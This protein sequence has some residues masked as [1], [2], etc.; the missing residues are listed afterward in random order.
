MDCS[1]HRAT[2]DIFGDLE[3]AA[4]R[5]M[6]NW[7]PESFSECGPQN[8]PTMDSDR[9]PERYCIPTP[10][11]GA[12]MGI[13]PWELS[14]PLGNITATY[15]N[16][17]SPMTSFTVCSIC[18]GVL[19]SFGT[20]DSCLGL[21]YDL[22]IP[23]TSEAATYGQV[24]NHMSWAEPLAPSPLHSLGDSTP[25]ESCKACNSI[26]DPLGSCQ[27]CSMLL[28]NAS[29]WKQEIANLHRQDPQIDDSAL[30]DSWLARRVGERMI[31][32]KKDRMQSGTDHDGKRRRNQLRPLMAQETTQ[33]EKRR[34]R[35]GVCFECSRRKV[36]C[37]HVK[38]A[39]M[40]EKPTAGLLI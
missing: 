15:N 7:F 20:C 34:T 16:Y 30:S 39:D 40:V 36:R 26:L 17:Q 6:N 8:Q 32:V 5:K 13:D 31:C 38:S 35:G 3:H 10:T 22:N 11:F 37:Y 28:W 1:S 18:Y 12:D 23:S 25:V 14:I 4:D 24:S 19:D 21:V 33:E 27:Y 29:D 2:F 9:V